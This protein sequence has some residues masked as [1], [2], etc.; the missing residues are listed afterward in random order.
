MN[1]PME[2]SS[3]QIPVQKNLS[4][5][6]SDILQAQIRPGNVATDATPLQRGELSSTMSDIRHQILRNMSYPFSS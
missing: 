1:T 3:S 6:I 4:A 5:N 2:K